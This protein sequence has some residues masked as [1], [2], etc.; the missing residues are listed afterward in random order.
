MAFNYCIQLP[1]NWQSSLTVNISRS[2]AIQPVCTVYPKHHRC[3]S[4]IA[5]HFV[6][7]RLVNRWISTQQTVDAPSLNAFKAKLT[8]MIY[9][10]KGFFMDYSPLSS[11]PP[12]WEWLTGVQDRAVSIDTNRT[13]TRARTRP[14]THVHGHKHGDV[15]RTRS[16]AWVRRQIRVNEQGGC[17]TRTRFHRRAQSRWCSKMWK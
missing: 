6:S 16:R 12:W 2:T 8:R 17:R 10:R 3:T 4:D 15:P 5:K 1:R 9:N 14:R 11:R 13:R 7:N